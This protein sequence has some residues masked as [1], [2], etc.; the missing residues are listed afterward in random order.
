[1][2]RALKAAEGWSALKGL[3]G[4]GALRPELTSR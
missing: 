4:R 2:L 3:L 1:M